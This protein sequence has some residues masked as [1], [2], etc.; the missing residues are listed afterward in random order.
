VQA[1]GWQ[2]GNFNWQGLP[3]YFKI[4]MADYYRVV[5]AKT[6]IQ[7]IFQKSI[8]ST[9]QFPSLYG[10]FIDIELIRHLKQKFGGSF[11]HSRIHDFFSGGLIAA[12]VDKYIRAEFPVT[13]NAT[14]KHSTGFATINEKNDQTAFVDLQKKEDN[15]PFHKDLVFIRSNAIPIAEAMLQ[16]HELVPTFPRVNF[17]KL[18]TEV[19]GEAAVSENYNRFL[20][21][22]NGVQQLASMNHLDK[23]GEELVKNTY[24]EPVKSVVKKKFS[25]ISLSLYVDT[26][27]SGINNIEDACNFAAYVIP[28]NFFELKNKPARYLS[29]FSSLYRYLCLKLFSDKRKLL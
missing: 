2:F 6:E 12:S 25:P 11:F 19:A 15:I 27:N 13:I 5:D 8:Y 21:L 16:V 17:K 23:Y 18:L 26:T 9:I 28:G 10:G 1:V 3:S 14:S 4:P 29:L 20:E 22:M 24:H 7:K